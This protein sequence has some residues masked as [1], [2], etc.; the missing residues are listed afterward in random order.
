M[1]KNTLKK[2]FTL[3][4]L[5]VVITIL[6]VL[7][8]IAFVAFQGGGEKAEKVSTK[9]TLQAY[10]SALNFYKQE[11]GKLPAAWNETTWKT[12]LANWKIGFL[13]SQSSLAAKL[14]GAKTDAI[15]RYIVNSTPVYYAVDASGQYYALWARYTE[16]GTPKIMVVTNYPADATKA[17]LLWKTDGGTWSANLNQNSPLIPGSDNDTSKNVAWL[18]YAVKQSD[19]STRLFLSKEQAALTTVPAMTVVTW[20]PIA[21]TVY[22]TTSTLAIDS[23]ITIAT[24]GNTAFTST[25][26]TIKVQGSGLGL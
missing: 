1:L 3:V 25:D 23:D 7:A 9:T 22:E 2:W 14:E 15:W 13:S 4:E 19:G 6:A 21:N 5:I 17:T 8:T 26:L 12:D 16:A 20:T 24:A 18:A 10:A 11:A